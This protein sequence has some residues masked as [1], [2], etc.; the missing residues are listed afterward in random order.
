MQFGLGPRSPK[1][2]SSVIRHL[3]FSFFPTHTMGRKEKERAILFS[4]SLSFF[5]F[6]C[7]FFCVVVVVV[8]VVMVIVVMIGEGGCQ[9]KKRDE[10][11]IGLR[12]GLLLFVWFFNVSVGFPPLLSPTTRFVF[13]KCEPPT[14]IAAGTQT[15]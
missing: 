8:V 14:L 11:T 1:R 12:F 7:L 9:K 13:L 15:G 6:V 3:S 2:F 10:G 5:L 4:F